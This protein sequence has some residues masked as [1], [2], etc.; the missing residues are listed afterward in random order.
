MASGSKSRANRQL[1]VNRF[2]VI[3]NSSVLNLSRIHHQ[4]GEIYHLARRQ[5]PVRFLESSDNHPTKRRNHPMESANRPII[6]RRNLRIDR[7]GC[8]DQGVESSDNRQ[9]LH[10][11]RQIAPSVR[12][13]SGTPNHQLIVNQFAVIVN[14]T[15]LN[16]SRIHQ[17]R[18]PIHQFASERSTSALAPQSSDRH[19]RI[20]PGDP[21]PMNSQLSATLPH[22]IRNRMAWSVDRSIHP[23]KRNLTTTHATGKILVIIT[24]DCSTSRARSRSFGGGSCL[25]AA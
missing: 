9:M 3:V 10:G 11:N 23:M 14:S 17:S 1:I 4:N 25:Y 13:R 21:T 8:R 24:P 16:P 7:S 20:R 2:P 19:P 12:R 18:A 5:P 15:A 6:D 22:Q